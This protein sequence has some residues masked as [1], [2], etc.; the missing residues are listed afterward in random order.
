MNNVVCAQS[1]SAW[2]DSGRTNYH[3]NGGSDTGQTVSVGS[4]PSPPPPEPSA[5]LEAQYK[6]K[7]NGI[8]VT[9]RAIKIR[10]ISDGTSH[11]AMYSERCLGDADNA[12]IE[13]PSDWFAISGTNQ[14]ADQVYTKCVAVTPV[15]GGL[16]W[17]CSGRNWSHGDYATSRYTHVMPPNSY[18][19]AQVSGALTAIPINEEGGAHTASS[20]HS[21]GVNMVTA[22]GG[23]HFVSNDVDRLVWSAIGS[24][25]GGEV[26]DYGW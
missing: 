20:R 7:N 21:G 19:C 12:R 4:A 13:T 9:N 24:R 1:N 16:Q 23:T 14:T 6:E 5:D 15:T 2:L 10:Q 22:D 25:N 8:Y 26:V 11:T 17:S 3:G 18:A